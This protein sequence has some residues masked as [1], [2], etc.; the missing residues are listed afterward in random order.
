VVLRSKSFGEKVSHI[1]N[2]RDVMHIDKIFVYT[3][4]NKMDADV[5]VFHC[6]VVL[7]VMCTV[8]GP[9]IVTI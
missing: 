8:N 3:V 2:T 7:W 5:D 1:V 9:S 6:E 4:A